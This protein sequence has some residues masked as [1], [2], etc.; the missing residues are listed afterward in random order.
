[1]K[2]SSYLSGLLFCLYIS[3]N[4]GPGLNA[5]ES[6]KLIGIGDLHRLRTISEPEVSPDGKWVVYTV[7]TTDPKEDTRNSDIWMTSMDGTNTLQLTFTKESEHLPRW[8]PDGKY[9]AFLSGRES[10]KKTEQLWLLN[11]SGGEARKVTDM[12][13]GISDYAWS[14]DGK[15]IVFVAD[16]PDT[17][18]YVTGTKTPKPIVIDR[19]YF[20]EDGQGYMTGIRH[21]LYLLEP[22]QGNPVI[23]TPGNFNED[24]PSWSPDGNTIAFTS[25]RANADFDRDNNYD[26]WLIEAKQGAS[27]RQLTTFGGPDGPPDYNCSPAWSP[28]GKYIA[29]L[30]GGPLKLISYAVNKL[31]VIPVT[32]GEPKILTPSLDRNVYNLQWSSD[33]KKIFGILEDD[34]NRDIFSI[35]SGGGQPVILTPGRHSVLSFD[36]KSGQLA[37]LVSDVAHP[38]EL[39]VLG[40]DVS[41]QI[42]HQ[43]DS[44]ISSW[45]IAPVHEISCK[46]KD[47]TI[48]HGF[49]M[50][51]PGY[52]KGRRYPLLLRIHG[53]PVAQFDNSFDLENQVFAA[54]G[55]VVITMN[56]RGSSG[57]GEKFSTAIFREWGIKDA[58]DVLAGV[59]DAISRGVGDPGR[60]GIGGWSYGGMLTNY[61]IAQ[62]TRFKCAISGAGVSNMLAA[63]G[64]D[65]YIRE[66]EQELGTPWHDTDNYLKVS[67]PFYNADK[68]ITPTLFL[69][70][71]IDFNVPLLNSEQMYQ[72]LQCLHIPTELIIYPGQPHGISKPSYVTDRMRRYLDW[73][74]RYLRK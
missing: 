68:I 49:E 32:G 12:K 29:Y 71:Q 47:G 2:Y 48:I 37:F 61:V 67:F 66:Y 45:Q 44:I 20:K 14:P 57:R 52:E 39:C 58:Q 64:T 10:E 24:L 7:R 13:G 70:G 27:P 54:N 26:L 73:Y 50:L 59:D 35:P 31:A 25:K 69:G 72:A 63:F 23:L 42:T 60:L 16:D 9:L 41:R 1:M 8:S 28:D 30:Q 19:Y 40:T 38:A 36:C 18:E 6:R 53:G 34:R 22:G 11:R 43:N 65:M 21:H 62:D 17:P 74:G 5:Q 51:P 46:S 56:P 15:R 4:N 33:G 3:V 55:Y